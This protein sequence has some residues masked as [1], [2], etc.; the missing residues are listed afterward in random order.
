MERKENGDSSPTIFCLKVAQVE[1]DMHREGFSNPSYVIYLQYLT[2]LCI[3]TKLE[4]KNYEQ[5]LKSIGPNHICSPQSQLEWHPAVS[6]LPV[7]RNKDE[8]FLNL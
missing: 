2:E 6:P 7:P 4:R 5:H 8:L 3:S 1:G